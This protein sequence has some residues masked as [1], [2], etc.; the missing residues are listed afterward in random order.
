MQTKTKSAKAIILALATIMII[1]T[2]LVFSACNKD[3]NGDTPSEYYAQRYD[4][5]LN[6]VVKMG[7]DIDFTADLFDGAYVKEKSGK[8]EITLIFSTGE[9]DIF[10]NKL[11]AFVNSAQSEDYR[12]DTVTPIFGYYKGDTLVTDGVVLTYSSGN[13]YAQNKDGKYYYVQS[14]SFTVD[15]LEEEYVL[16]LF[17]TAGNDT[18]V[19][20]MQ[21]PYAL[22]NGGVC[23][24]NLKLDLSKSHES[25][26]IASLLGTTS[27]GKVN[28]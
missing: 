19:S 26:N 11:T 13:N 15:S 18:M 24:A 16:S 21:F 27:L 14:M 22:S 2:L 12:G 10:G 20:S 23:N 17:V 4:A 7:N 8:Y 5:Q 3:D 28:E 9:V 25:E 1:A 6:G